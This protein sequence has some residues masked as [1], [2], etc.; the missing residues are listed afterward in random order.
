MTTSVI[1]ADEKVTDTEILWFLSTLIIK[2]NAKF[3][4]K[5]S[6]NAVVIFSHDVC[7]PLVDLF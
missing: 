2:E 3:Q 1:S 6:E 4:L 5:V 7:K